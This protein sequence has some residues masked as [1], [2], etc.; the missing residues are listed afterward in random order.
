ML[1]AWKVSVPSQSEHEDI[2]TLDVLQA[3]LESSGLPGSRPSRAI[4]ERM[5]LMQFDGQGY[6]K[7]HACP[8]TQW[9]L[10][11]VMLR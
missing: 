8:Q 2:S 5:Q 9:T 7:S 11:W 4:I 3:Y 6:Y 10:L 1:Y